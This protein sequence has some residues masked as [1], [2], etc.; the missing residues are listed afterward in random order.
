MNDVDAFDGITSICDC[1]LNHGRTCRD[2]STGDCQLWEQH[3]AH[4]A[5][6][7]IALGGVEWKRLRRRRIPIAPEQ[8]RKI[9][10]SLVSDM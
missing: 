10:D 4:R 5:D 2:T 7:L 6:V 8:L 9:E 3:V 1:P